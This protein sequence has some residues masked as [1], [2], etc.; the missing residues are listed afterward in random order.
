MMPAGCGSV[1]GKQPS[2]VCGEEESSLLCLAVHSSRRASNAGIRDGWVV[3][4]RGRRDGA[5]VCV[6]SAARGVGG[7]GS[8]QRRGTVRQ[9]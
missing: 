6:R 7:S 8:C 3:A 4:A 2:C 9:V 1:V 5:G